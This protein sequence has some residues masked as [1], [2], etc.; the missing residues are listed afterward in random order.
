MVN[1][2]ESLREILVVVNEEIQI[3]LKISSFIPSI[4]FLAKNRLN[5]RIICFIKS[6][7]FSYL[8]CMHNL[9]S[10]VVKFEESDSRIF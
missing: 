4:H 10:R 9:I 7:L 6:E 3:M 8:Y 1:I 2:I 5:S